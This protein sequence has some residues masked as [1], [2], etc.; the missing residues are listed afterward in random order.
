MLSRKTTGSHRGKN[1]GEPLRRRESAQRE[2]EYVS[3]DLTPLPTAADLPIA[4]KGPLKRK[5]VAPF[6]SPEHYPLI[7]QSKDVTSP[8]RSVHQPHSPNSKKKKLVTYHNNPYADAVGKKG[9]RHEVV[10][11]LAHEAIDGQPA[12]VKPINVCRHYLQGKCNRG[13]ICRFTHLEQHHIVIRS[14][15]T[16]R[17]TPHRSPAADGLSLPH[18]DFALPAASSSYSAY[19]SACALASMDAAEREFVTESPALELDGP[20]SCTPET[21]S[22]NQTYVHN[23]YDKTLTPQRV[24]DTWRN[25]PYDTTVFQHPCCAYEQFASSFAQDGDNEEQWS[26]D[27]DN[28]DE[29]LPRQAT[30][31][32]PH[33]E[34]NKWSA[35]VS[36]NLSG[37]PSPYL[38]L[39]RW[40]DRSEEEVIPFALPVAGMGFTPYP[41]PSHYFTK[42]STGSQRSGTTSRNRSTPKVSPFQSTQQSEAAQLDF[43]RQQEEVSEEAVLKSLW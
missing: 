34:G 27:D 32:P 6:C 7:F 24:E 41:Q 11:P 33:D 22:P 23:P 39:P 26:D 9:E 3:Q 15:R 37:V 35:K 4:Q 42:S 25:S 10:A 19:P 12:V 20:S 38:G 18:D 30:E 43:R 2:C 16:P 13:N 40:D 14:S 8:T 28:D 21:K 17:M 36:P 29:P 31:E 5:G 1:A